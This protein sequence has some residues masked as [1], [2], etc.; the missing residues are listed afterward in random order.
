MS[1]STRQAVDAIRRKLREARR[2]L[3]FARLAQ[4]LVALLACLAAIWLVLAGA[5]TLLW[6]P[7]S[8]RTA[9]VIG[10]IA[11]LIFV[12]S[13]FMLDPAARLVGLLAHPREETVARIVEAKVPPAADRLLNIL[14]LSSGR[15][16]RS[17][18]ALVDG[19]INMLS[20][21]IA[22]ISFDAVENFERFQRTVRYAMIP[23]AGLIVV[24][25]TAPGPFFGATARLMHLSESFA[26][27]APFVINVEPGD[28]EIIR[29]DSLMVRIT[30]RGKAD[31]SP[32]LEFRRE[33]ERSVS[34][35]RPTR[36][37]PTSFDYTESNV[38]QSFEYRV[39]ARPVT[40]AWYKVDV[41]DRP[42][43]RELSVAIESPR[44]SRI[45]RQELGAN[46]GDVSALP[47]SRIILTAELGGSP[48]GTAEVV[49][50]DGTRRSLSIV[51]GVASGDFT[52]VRSG[53]YHVEL[54]SD[55]GIMSVSPIT[56]R[57]GL[58]TDGP[59]SVSII[60]PDVTA[61]LSEPFEP[62]LT[63]RMMDDYG[64]HRVSLMYRLAQSRFGSVRESFTELPIETFKGSDLDQVVE[65][66]W[67]MKS[68]SGLSPVPGDVFEYFI[69]VWDNDTFS[70]YKST[71][72]RT[73]TFVMPS[74]ADRFRELEEESDE[75]TDELEDLLDKAGEVG[76]RFDELR[77]ELR[78]KPE[79]DWDDSRELEQ[80]QDLQQEVDQQLED[81]SQDVNDLVQQ[82]QDNSLLSDETMEVYE[83]LQRAIEEISSPELMEALQKLREAMQSMDLQQMQQAMQDFE[84]N[85]DQFKERLE[86]ALDLFKRLKARQGLEEAARRAEELAGIQEELQKETQKLLDEKESSG[87]EKQSDER[88]A[89]NPDESAEGDK[90]AENNEQAE[91]LARQQ[92]QA[93]AEMKDLQEQLEQLQ[94]MLEEIP[95]VPSNQLEQI[96]S[97]LEDQDIPQQMKDNAEQLRQQ[98]MQPAMQ[99]QQQMQQQLQNL[100][101]QLSDMQQSMAGKQLQINMAGLRQALNDV[102]ILSQQQEATKADVE[103]TASD[104]P[105][106]R[107]YAK[108]QIELGEGLRV[109]SDTLQKLSREIPEMSREVQVHTGSAL[110]EMSQAT[111][112][113]ADRSARRAAGHQKGSMMHL[114]EL[115]LLL[116]DLLNMLMNQQ[117]NMGAPSMQQM[118]D[119]LQQMAGQQQQL[120]QQIQEML[121]DMQ[122][123]RLT[124][125]M[126]AR[127]RQ[128]GEQQE[129]IKQELK[130]LS[131]NPEL[132][133]K[134]LGDLD[135]IAEQMEETIRELQQFR[136]DRNMMQRQ[137]EILTRLL[138]ASRSMNKR[139]REKRR[140][141]QSGEEIDRESPGEFTP[142][143][144]ADQLRRDLIRALESGYSRDYEELI[145]RYFEL[146][147]NAQ[148]VESE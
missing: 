77:D 7:S 104:S 19:A 49:F 10:A 67:K 38:R 115:A 42:V 23:L 132:R 62:A 12:I 113:L 109:V 81:I 35:S 69:R 87:Q 142:D 118:L 2:R 147:Q 21:P 146:L 89:V 60:K 64:V 135:R 143:E 108:H 17:P 86:R 85:E 112:A 30:I 106:L 148:P 56:Y 119:Q 117:M 29:G 16:S 76:E 141:S 74:L 65:R 116:S 91:D 133:G 50:D 70:G 58:L 9:V 131:R 111:V 6:M 53:S 72:S 134:A 92:E 51:D 124:N 54:V 101:Q 129:K 15:H 144:R 127:I 88:E 126:Q 103:G 28:A 20:T 79:A 22:A 121:N 71:D 95:R 31:V 137:Q 82:L 107:Q 99:G 3:L 66:I 84:F 105:T 33:G 94:E 11:I 78:K 24:L 138:D 97:Q 52:L 4:G 5:E 90:S 96:R 39:V 139:G 130:E 128:L 36:G 83:Q 27:P 73:H 120:N 8:A 48:A 13:R 61:E 59:P 32:E 98:Q 26:K 55:E 75:T 145:K 102:L 34:R 40:S 44:Y 1:E 25:L 46:V 122:G 41:V 140:E 47:G 123:Q 114:N 100:Q 57:L 37:S 68:E 45:G 80:I 43:V 93:E 63:A 14:H 136:N 18:D 125:D 110:R